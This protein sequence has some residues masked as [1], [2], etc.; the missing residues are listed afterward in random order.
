MQQPEILTLRNVL[1]YSL[2]H[3]RDNIA[4]SFTDDSPIRFT[5]L[6]KSVEEMQL[7]LM[8]HGISKGDRVAILSQNMPNWGIAY[9]AIT[10]LGAVAVPLLPDFS[11]GE[12]SN[13]LTHSG[14]K[15]LFVSQRLLSKIEQ[16]GAKG[17]A[18]QIL[19]DDFSLIAFQGENPIVPHVKGIPARFALAKLEEDDLASII[20]TSGTTGRSKG[21]ML[22]HKNLVFNARQVMTIQPIK[23]T[24]LFLSV[25]PLSHT[26]ENTLGLILPV[27]QG[28]SVYYLKKSPTASVLLPA[29]I[30]V[31]PTIMLTVPMIIEKIYKVQVLGKFSGSYIKRSIYKFSLFRKLIHRLAGKK[32][33]K[34]FGG[35]LHFYGIGG[36]KLDPIVERFL[37][38]ARF[39][40]GIG[41]GLTET[42]PMLAGSNP[43]QT[44][45]QAVGPV[46]Q[47]V[48]LKIE[49]PDPKSGN[50][51]IF[52]KGPNVM[53]GYYRD[54]EMTNEVM[55]SDGWFRTGDLGCFDKNG[56][57]FIKGRLKN[58]ILTASGENIYPE[59]I[60]SLINNFNY[61]VESIVIEKK[62]KLVALVH[63]DLEALQK[64]FEHMKEEARTYFTETLNA[65]Q[66]E[67]IAYVNERVNKYS[68]LQG[69]ELMP[70]PFE[71]TPT[72]KIKRYLYY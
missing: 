24:D 5:D 15:G 61:V 29:L 25:L 18:L 66:D 64:Q 40:Y 45:W 71:K 43:S 59:D 28:A 14:A 41:Y 55:T 4:F 46:M 10:T 13:I 38:E 68:R 53:K 63:F 50:G 11:A 12:I 17:L 60:E 1:A 65:L 7:F 23:S 8:N 58:M 3:Y 47:G 31:R 39:P 56:Y 54:Q 2:D 33:L 67:L 6:K 20:Y 9:F 30:E 48:E 70:T 26:Y 44:K 19:I 27:M 57:L 34:A 51:E 52:A 22:T 32:L 35:R 72:L 42:A 69:I 62:G 16:E 36:A 37:R 49:N 21:V